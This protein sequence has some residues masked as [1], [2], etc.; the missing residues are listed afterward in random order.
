MLELDSVIHAPNRLKIC[1]MLSAISELDFQLLKAELDVSDSV[2]SK[3]IKAL[4][5]AGYLIAEKRKTSGRPTTWLKLTTAGRK[6][7]NEHVAALKSIVG[8]L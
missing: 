1:A 8:E 7:F 5:S 4:E 6:A 3:H 2:L